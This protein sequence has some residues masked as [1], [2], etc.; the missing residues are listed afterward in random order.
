MALRLE[1]VKWDLPD[2]SGLNKE[3]IKDINLKFDDGKLIVVTGPNGGGK[4]T[5]AK[6]IAGVVMPKSGKIFLSEGET[7]RDITELDVTER[8]R[9]GIAYA[10]Q[11][12]VRFK[13]L[14][15]RNLLEIAAGRTM[16]QNELCKLLG[17]VG[18]CAEEYINR[19]MNTS[20]SG[21]ESKRIEIAT[22]LARNAKISV[23]DEPEAGI[24]L[25][26]FNSLIKVFEKMQ[27]NN[28][29]S[30]LIISHQERILDI[31]DEIVLLADGVIKAHGSKEE[32]LPMVLGA[33]NNGP[34][35]KLQS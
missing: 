4:T 31:A 14:T 26:S 13:G 34:C 2:D 6:L 18:L 22:V 28:K 19:E 21:G 29:N 10:F 5:L 8:A 16:S 3:I 9:S 25:W 24:D 11:Q 27:K 35:A 17:K 1:H 23:F 20:L 12:P 30:I 33:E 15:V 32:I 7:E